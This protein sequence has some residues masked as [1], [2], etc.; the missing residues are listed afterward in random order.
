MQLEAFLLCDS[1]AN[2]GGMLSILGVFDTLSATSEPIV[3]RRA[4][5]TL[6]IRFD[7]SEEGK[8]TFSLILIDADGRPAGPRTDGEA[9]IIMPPDCDSLASNLTIDLIPLVIPRFG[10]YRLDL[11]LDGELKAG[12]PLFVRQ[13]AL[14]GLPAPMG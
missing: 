13:V 6:R 7:R 1:A 2:H 14:P 9:H 12:L 8:H 10:A 5:I 4:A 3:H 11:I